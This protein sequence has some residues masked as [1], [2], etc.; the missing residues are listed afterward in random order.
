MSTRHQNF[1]WLDA[2]VSRS[3]IIL[4]PFFLFFK[5]TS[6]SSSSSSHV[7]LRRAN[8]RRQRRTRDIRVARSTMLD[9]NNISQLSAGHLPSHEFSSFLIVLLVFIIFLLFFLTCFMFITFVRTRLKRRDTNLIARSETSETII[10]ST[11]INN[12]HL[13]SYNTIDSI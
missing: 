11:L 13:Q 8:V 4:L 9:V 12:N 7:R 2:K 3:F 5:A 10:E 1:K 6:S